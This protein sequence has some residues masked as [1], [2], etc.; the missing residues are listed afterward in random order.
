[1][2][3][4]LVPYDFSETANHALKFATSLA[5]NYPQVE[6]SLLHVVETPVTTGMG[7]MGGGL[8]SVPA[9]ENQVFFMELIETR[10]NQ[11]NKLEEQY[12]DSPFGFSTKIVV[13]NVFKGISETINDQNPDLI[14]MGS[15]GTTGLEEVI[16]GSNTEK[17][18]RSAN[19]PVITIK[20]ETD[21]RDMKKIVFAS[22]FRDSDEEVAK[23]FKRMQKLF[24]AEFYF[25]VVNTPGNFETTRESMSRIKTY[26]S[27]HKFENIKAEIYN[28]LSEESGILEFADDID[29][30]LIAMTTH[31]RT[32]LIHLI[33][34]SI[35]EDV[36]NHS[37]RPVWTYKR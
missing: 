8:E 10:K 31:G 32:G 15:K 5:N 18:V 9:F 22:D 4:V 21:V 20:T 28:S 36:V 13:G 7:T 3:K 16:I 24:N 35:A 2:I 6:L 25:V 34:G 33:T 1:M 14:I 29:A 19:C 37:K 26:V 11:F 17:V 30:D 12:K 27:K 23:R